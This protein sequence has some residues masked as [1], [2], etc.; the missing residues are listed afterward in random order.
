MPSEF[1][2]SGRRMWPTCFFVR[3]WREHGDYARSIIEHVYERRAGESEAIAS[4]VAL[5]AKSSHGLFESG[6]NLFQETRHEGVLRLREFISES[7]AQAV[8]LVNG[9]KLAPDRLRVEFTESWFHITNTGGIHDAHYH[10]N[11]SWCGIYYVLA[12]ESG[13]GEGGTAGNGIN[14]F[15]SPLPTGGML[16]DYGNAYIASNRLDIT[17]QDGMVILFP[18]YVLHSALAYAGE[19][20]RIVI[21]FNTRSYPAD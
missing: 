11:C 14:R 16:A 6:L 12:G 10:S 1:D 2:L 5:G 20:D 17:P 18:S 9:R 3:K 15:Y 13:A 7:V 19:Q 4:R 21:A 8:S